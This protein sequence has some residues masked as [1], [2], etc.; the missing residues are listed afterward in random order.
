MAKEFVHKG[1]GRGAPA[2]RGGKKTKRVEDSKKRLTSEDGNSISED[3]EADMQTQTQAKPE[4]TGPVFY[5]CL[6]DPGDVKQ[7]NPGESVP[8]CRYCGFVMVPV[9]QTGREKRDR[10]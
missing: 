4:A 8:F 5:R 3:K 1:W 9:G 10:M 7:R 6:S 2:S